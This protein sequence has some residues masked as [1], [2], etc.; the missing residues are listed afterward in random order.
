MIEIYNSVCAWEEYHPQDKY[1]YFQVFKNG[2]DV[3]REYYGRK[4]PV[5]DAINI[6]THGICKDECYP[7][8]CKQYGLE[9]KVNKK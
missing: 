4:P 2:E 1:M 8:V 6:I 9:D 7:N 3:T 5:D